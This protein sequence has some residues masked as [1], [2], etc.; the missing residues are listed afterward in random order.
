MIAGISNLPAGWATFGHPGAT[1]LLLGALAAGRLSHA[2]LIT[3][4]PQTGRKTL[5]LDLARAVN[6]RPAMGLLGPAPESAA[7]GP[8][9]AA[10]ER[11]CGACS[12]CLRIARGHHADVRVITVDTPVRKDKEKDDEE[13]VRHKLIRRGHI[14]D[15]Q[16]D[17]S[18]KSF[19]GGHR[20]FII[21]GAE[22]M[23]P[24]A[25]NT[26]LKTLEEPAPDVLIL[27]IATSAAALLPTIV[28]RC[29]VLDLRPVSAEA[30]ER[31]L[32]ERFQAEPALAAMLGRL[33]RGRPGWA[34]AALHDPALLERHTQAVQRVVDALSGDLEARFQ[35]AGQLSLA[36]RRGREDVLAEL[37]L[38][39]EWWRDVAVARCGLDS[40]VINQDRLPLLKALGAALDDAAITAAAASIA[41]TRRALEA[42]AIPRL[43]LE[44]M[45]LDLPYVSVAAPSPAAVPASGDPA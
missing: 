9:C 14:V 24:D 36:F 37:D 28:S 3:G 44:V 5:A 13:T 10:Q 20:V 41:D 38:W 39:L 6:C 33:A 26:L 34:V 45:M 17:A 30:I 29:H 21:D 40:L 43:A 2:Y 35:Y 31:A 4:A 22:L 1:R 12:P 19:E 18:L 16:K 11:P 23:S 15:L 25:A 32:V 8:D 27:L 42:N 7:P